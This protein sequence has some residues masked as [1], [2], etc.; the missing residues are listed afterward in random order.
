[1][2]CDEDLSGITAM[3]PRMA[4]QPID[5]GAALAGNLGDRH[6]RAQRVT[7][8]GDRDAVGNHAAGDEAELL[9]A[10]RTPVAAVNEHQYRRGGR[11][12][13]KDIDGLGRRRAEGNVEP[14]LGRLAGDEAL[15]HAVG[16]EGLM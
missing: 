2:S 13:W 11:I 16:S 9:A 12:G 6:L 14:A 8:D 5:G 7:H 1:M 4:P 3:L 15:A 10:E